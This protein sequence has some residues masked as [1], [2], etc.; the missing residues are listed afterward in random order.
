MFFAGFNII[1]S[2]NESLLRYEGM[3]L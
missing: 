3:I 2:K 1:N